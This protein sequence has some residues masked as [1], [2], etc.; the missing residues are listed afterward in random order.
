MRGEKGTH[1]H[2]AIRRGPKTP[3]G[4][5]DRTRN[6]KVAKSCQKLGCRVQG[7]GW[8]KREAFKGNTANLP[9]DFACQFSRAWENI[10]LLL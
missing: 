10:F 5:N 6:A 7:A 3:E 1:R 9:L 4:C 2:R 8:G